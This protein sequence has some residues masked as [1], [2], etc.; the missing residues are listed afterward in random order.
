MKKNAEYVGVDEKY[1]PEEERYVEGNSKKDAKIL[2]GVGI[3]YLT[4]ITFIFIAVIAVF[5]IVIMNF[6]DINNKRNENVIKEE[7]NENSEMIDSII[8]DYYNNN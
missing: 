6:V 1:I 8:D 2:K 5:G 4:F 3:G 7:I